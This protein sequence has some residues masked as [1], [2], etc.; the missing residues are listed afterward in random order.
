MSRGEEMTD[1]DELIQQAK[2]NKMEHEQALEDSWMRGISK[3]I[4]YYG[5][6]TRTEYCGTKYGKQYRETARKLKLMGF[7]VKLV[8]IRKQTYDF[9]FQTYCEHRYEVTHWR[10]DNE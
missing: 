5:K 2:F 6:A 10:T 1:A 8:R 9:S 7:R 4:V 3:D